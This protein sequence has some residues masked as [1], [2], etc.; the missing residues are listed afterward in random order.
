MAGNT[1]FGMHTPPDSLPSS[2]IGAF[3]PFGA[4]PFSPVSPVDSESSLS[5]MRPSYRASMLPRCQA[6]Q[7]GLPAPANLQPTEMSSFGSLFTDPRWTGVNPLFGMWNDPTGFEYM[8]QQGLTQLLSGNIPL[9]LS[10]CFDQ[11]TNNNKQGYKMLIC[12]LFR[13]IIIQLA[14][15]VT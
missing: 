9:M 2:P 15:L 3:S 7:I 14:P 4:F 12:S 10:L 5:P 6:R 13:I 1:H 11:S 8:Q